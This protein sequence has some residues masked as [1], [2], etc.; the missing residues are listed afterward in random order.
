MLKTKDQ[1]E[2][3]LTTSK[4]TGILS[5]I[6]MIGVK[7]GLMLVKNKSTKIDEEST[8]FLLVFNGKLNSSKSDLSNE[9]ESHPDIHVVE[10][11]VLNYSEDLS[12]TSVKNEHIET[13]LVSNITSKKLQAI[14]IITP[15]SKQ[16]AVDKLVGLLGPVASMLVESATEKT[17]HIG[18]LYLLLSDELE[19][20]EK[21]E[22]LELVS[23]LDLKNLQ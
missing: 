5:S 2:L 11:V 7:Y 13:K 19:G 6:M 15:E 8:R 23:G 16:I 18:D 10:Q 3:I 1:V 4:K 22:F 9:L 17:K 14:D 21:K 12:K 20:E